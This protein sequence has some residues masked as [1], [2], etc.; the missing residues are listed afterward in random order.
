MVDIVDSLKWIKENIAA[1][2]GDPDNV[3][4]FGESG[5][6]AKILT[7]MSAPSAKGLFQKGIVQS[8]A[9]DT[10]GVSFTPDNFIRLPLLKI[11]SHKADQGGAPVYA[12]VFTKQNENNVAGVYHTAEIPYV[13]SNTPKQ[14]K[15]ATTMSIA[16]ANFARYGKP[17]APGLPG[18]EGYN[19]ETQATMILDDVSTLRYN[20]DKKLLKALAPNYKY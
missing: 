5:G 11:M 12:Y 17:Y 14:E 8:G 13:F 19:R 7:L 18:G 9:I 16:W 4:I 20:H 15:L 1:F 10:M 6:G 2:G 3:A